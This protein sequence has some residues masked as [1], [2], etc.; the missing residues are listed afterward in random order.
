MATGQRVAIVG[1]GYSQIG[2]NSGL[3]A[4]DHMIQATKAA[5]ADAGLT[6]HDIDGVTS[7]GTEPLNDA[8]L[9]GIEPVNWWAT[10]MMA[11]AFS[12]SATQAIAAVASGFCHTALALR[13]IQQAFSRLAFNAKGG[14]QLSHFTGHGV[15]DGPRRSQCRQAV[16]D[17]LGAVLDGGD[18]AFSIRQREVCLGPESEGSVSEFYAE[19]E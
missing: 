5:L 17:L 11:P 18:F 3:T 14:A 2:R 16:A 4:N 9:L 13:V 12:Y 7:V 8:W 6:V 1:L 10:G 19:R 15:V